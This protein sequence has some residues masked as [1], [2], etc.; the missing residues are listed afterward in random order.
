[1]RPRDPVRTPRPARVRPR[2]L[3]SL[4]VTLLV[5]AFLSVGLGRLSWLVVRQAGVPAPASGAPAAR[6]AT[7][8]VAAAWQAPSL[9]PGPGSRRPAAGLCP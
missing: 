3:R 1:M 8:P 7:P 6:P 5:I 9:C 4:A 2:R